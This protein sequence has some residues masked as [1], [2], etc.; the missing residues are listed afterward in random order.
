MHL[1]IIV[2]RRVEI[3]PRDIHTHTDITK[4]KELTHVK[5]RKTD[6]KIHST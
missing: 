4:D 3:E 1:L 6:E 5:E 2:L